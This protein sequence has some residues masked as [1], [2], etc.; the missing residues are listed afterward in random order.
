MPHDSLWDVE[1]AHEIKVEAYLNKRYQ[2]E[3]MVAKFNLPGEREQGTI[4]NLKWFVKNGHKANSLRNG[5]KDAKKLA[6][7]ILEELKNGKGSSS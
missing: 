4:N 2:W 3:E 7:E 1:L 6:E 5:F